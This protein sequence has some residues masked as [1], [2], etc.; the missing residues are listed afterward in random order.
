MSAILSQGHHIWAGFLQRGH[1]PPHRV[2]EPQGVPNLLP[3]PGHQNPERVAESAVGKPLLRSTL[4]PCPFQALCSPRLPCCRWNL[5]PEVSPHLHLC[6]AHP[7]P[8]PSCGHH[9]PPSSLEHPPPTALVRIC[10]GLQG[11]HQILPLPGS[12]LACLP[13]RNVIFLYSELRAETG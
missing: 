1:P 9:S 2:P 8:T 3:R 12:L 6:P 4:S 13:P 11:P 5:A 7:L 10:P